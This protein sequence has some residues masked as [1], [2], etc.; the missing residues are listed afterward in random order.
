[1]GARMKIRSLEL[2]F[3]V[4][5]CGIGAVFAIFEQEICQHRCWIDAASDY[6]LPSTFAPYSGALPWVAIG[7]IFI[8]AAFRR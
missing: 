6:V 8:G 7:L 3:G 5:V 4:S 2:N 1:M